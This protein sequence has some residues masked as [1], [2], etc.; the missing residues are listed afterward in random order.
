MKVPK[1][2]TLIELLVVIAIIAILASMLLPALNQA[3][4]RAK[5]TACMNNLKQIGVALLNYDTGEWFPPRKDS[6]TEWFSWE[7]NIVT[8]AG[9]DGR[10]DK[11][12]STS[13]KYLAC[14]L[15]PLPPAG[16][17]KTKLSYAFNNGRSAE[18]VL[19]TG[20]LP[21]P[22]DQAFRL[23]KVKINSPELAASNQRGNAVLLAD[24]YQDGGASQN[25]YSAGPTAA[26][27]D[28][29]PENGHPGQGGGRN[30]LMSGLNVKA[31]PSAVFFTESLKRNLFDW[32]IGY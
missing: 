28:F 23:D 31:I 6:K 4:T 12:F 16:G 19:T 21:I 9:G 27:W 5:S 29:K 11:R 18:N 15:D 1:P 24:R 25:Q 10:H 17:K 20:N 2:F 8:A 30:A 32:Q 22:N 3:R 14:P 26:W 7:E 13:V